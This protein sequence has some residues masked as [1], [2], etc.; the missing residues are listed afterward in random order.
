[1]VKIKPI[2]ILLLITGLLS[3]SCRDTKT[4]NPKGEARTIVVD[5][6]YSIDIP[7]NMRPTSGLNA[8]ASLQYQDVQSEAYTLVIHE[9]RE[10]LLQLIGSDPNRSILEPYREIRMQ[11]LA[12]G[13]QVR[14]HTPVKGHLLNGLKAESLEV[15][16]LVEGIDSELS[17]FLT[18]VEGS[19][20][21]YMIMSWTLKE[22]KEEH[23]EAFRAIA[24]SFKTTP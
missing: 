8:E 11:L 5:G 14:S 16:A 6:L 2:A 13:T 24:A 4:N 22:R 19:G 10:D 12:E 7:P 17:Y 1:M 18:F 3:P 9:P 21:V 15:D 20:H 23:K